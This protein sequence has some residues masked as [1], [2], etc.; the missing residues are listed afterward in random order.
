M[1]RLPHRQRRPRRHLR[2]ARPA[3]RRRAARHRA[4]SP[5]AR[6]P[7][8]KAASSSSVRRTMPRHARHADAAR[9]RSIDARGCTVV[10]GFVDPHTHLVFA[11][12]RRDELQRR[13]AGATYAEIAAAGGGIVKT[14]GAPRA[15]PASTSWST[16]RAPR[17]AEMLACGTTTAEVKS[18][19][20]LDAASRAAGCCAR[21][22]TVAGGQP[23]EL[24]ATFMG[25]H[26]VPVEYRGR[27]GDYVRA[28][29][30][31]DDPGGRRGAAR[32]V[33]RRVLR[34]RA[35]SRPT[36][37]APSSRPASGTA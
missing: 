21:F 2:R 9:A 1:R 30:R 33:V 15:R 20:G 8:S 26:E 7:A 28:G 4:R 5:R 16:A 13:L 37:R 18:G 34:A 12:D 29:H 31:R 6:S 14:V 22:A 25:A 23:I 10:P 27:R 17:L 32:R 35:C 36:N 11:G 24:T 19:Y 3:A